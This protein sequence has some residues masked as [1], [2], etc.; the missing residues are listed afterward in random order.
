VA[1]EWESCVH[2][3]KGKAVVQNQAKRMLEFVEAAE[4]GRLHECIG[5]GLDD[6]SNISCNLVVGIIETDKRLQEANNDDEEQ[7]KE[8][9]GLLHHH[10]EHN[11]HGAKEPVRVQV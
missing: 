8:Y 3:N 9:D 4:V 7:G 6:K 10:L 5:H 1:E 11:E 2:Y